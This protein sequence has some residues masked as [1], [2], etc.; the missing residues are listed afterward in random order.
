LWIERGWDGELIDADVSHLWR[1]NGCGRFGSPAFIHKDLAG[2]YIRGLDWAGSR[3]D[4]TVTL[5]RR[6][7][8][9]RGMVT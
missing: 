4:G 8:G 2:V 3:T 6:I 7:Y 5:T 1:W 9:L